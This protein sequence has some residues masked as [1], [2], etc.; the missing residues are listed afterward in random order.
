VKGITEL[1]AAEALA[2]PTITTLVGR[3]E[4]DGLVRREA[5][6]ADARA[7]RVHL[8]DAGLARLAEMKIAREAVLEARL[9]GLTP[10]ERA[11]LLAALPLLDALTEG[12]E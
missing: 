7:V 6:P 4:R 9:A 3:L 11:A 8:T 12:E 1:A 5:D 10:D 2:Q